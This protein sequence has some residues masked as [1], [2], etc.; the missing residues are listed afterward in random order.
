M[1]YEQI[2]PIIDAL[3]LFLRRYLETEIHAI[4]CRISEAGDA[5]ESER[6]QL[7]RELELFE[8]LC[9]RIPPPDLAECPE[10][11]Q[12]FSPVRKDQIYCSK[13]CRD[14][15]GARRTG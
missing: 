9:K 7:W 8:A 1:E 3:K 12:K 11:G 4:R 10:C 14:V 2:K 13:L 5:A 15:V 6:E